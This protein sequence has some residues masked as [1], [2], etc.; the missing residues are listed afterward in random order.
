MKSINLLA[1][2]TLVFLQ[3]SLVTAG[4]ADLQTSDKEAISIV[5]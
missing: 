5:P 1:M 4:G 3:P 2:F